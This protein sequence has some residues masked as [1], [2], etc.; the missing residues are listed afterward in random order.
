MNSFQVSATT[1]RAGAAPKV[2]TKEWS[3]VAR[4]TAEVGAVLSRRMERRIER[5][6]V[7]QTP[8]A[9]ERPVV[10]T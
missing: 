9:G 4:R 8:S 1:G 10:P 7:D 3:G 5:A 6:P 2:R